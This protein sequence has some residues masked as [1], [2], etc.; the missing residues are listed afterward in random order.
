METGTVFLDNDA[1]LE[2]KTGTDHD[3]QRAPVRSTARKR[4]VADAGATASNS[5]L[6][7]LTSDTGSFHLE[8]GAQGR[9]DRQ[10]ERHRQR[11]VVASMAPIIFGGGAPA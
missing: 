10:S 7:G 6:T 9:D 2:F 5:A 3:D 1:L 8:H 11:Q 4:C